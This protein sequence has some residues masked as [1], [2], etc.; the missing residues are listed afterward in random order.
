MRAYIIERRTNENGVDD[1]MLR[2]RRVIEDEEH[3]FHCLFNWSTSDRKY[4]FTSVERIEGRSWGGPVKKED[5]AA[6]SQQV[7]DELVAEGYIL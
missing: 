6:T 4:M 1:L 7:Y 5:K 2:F 3:F